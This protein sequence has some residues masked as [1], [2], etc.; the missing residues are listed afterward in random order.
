MI[1]LSQWEIRSILW[2][3]LS[4]FSSKEKKIIRKD[5]ERGNHTDGLKG[6]TGEEMSEFFKRRSRYERSTQWVVRQ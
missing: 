1:G 5:D 2:E 6:I 3:D 4:F